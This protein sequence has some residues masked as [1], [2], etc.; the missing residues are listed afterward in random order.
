MKLKFE[1]LFHLFLIS[2]VIGV[3]IS[4]SKIYLFHIMLCLLL[5]FYTLSFFKIGKIRLPKM[6][7]KLHYIF[8]FMLAWYAAT[9]IWSINKIYTMQYLFYIACGTTIVL[10][11]IY[12]AKDIDRQSKVFNILSIP[13]IIEIII[14]LMEAFGIFRWPISPYSN[15]VTYFGREM[16]VNLN[17]PYEKLVYISRLPTGFQWNP[18]NLAATMIII[19][20]FFLFYKRAFVKYIGTFSVS[21]IIIM[22][23]SRGNIIALIFMMILHLLFFSRKKK[24]VFLLLLSLL[25]LIV[26]PSFI[27]KVME[28]ENMHIQK[29]VYSF[30]ALKRYLSKD[31]TIDESSIGIRKQLIKNG[32]NA[33]KDT[34]GLGVGGGC[35]RAVQ[36]KV[37][38][39]AGI[40]SMHNFWIEMLVDSGVL[41][42]TLFIIW[43][44]YT[45]FY[46]YRISR[47]TKYSE[48]KYYSSASS[49]AMVGFSVGAISASSVIYLL[50]MWI[51]FGFSIMTINNYRRIKQ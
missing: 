30:E 5:F 2:A 38:G 14:C 25:T 12:Y 19:L 35:S 32:I 7:T 36:E 46:L 22:T 31:T 16:G 24:I 43:Y 15:Y 44:L 20:P 27:D 34:Y 17:L 41:F 10:T 42:T 40:T 48:I 9:I 4:Y 37:E 33:L 11:L 6:P 1:S 3:G 8:Y 26:F 50:P 49:L 29:I 13:F 28:S 39:V 18:N 51:M 45:V 47:I 23:G 21:F